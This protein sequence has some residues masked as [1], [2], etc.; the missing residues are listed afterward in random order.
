MRLSLEVLAHFF[1]GV[2]AATVLFLEPK[3]LAAFLVLFLYLTFFSYKWVKKN[4]A[5]DVMHQE[6]KEWAFGFVIGLIAWATISFR[7]SL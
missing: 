5:H 3:W 1:H 4:V 6:L 2:L 7:F